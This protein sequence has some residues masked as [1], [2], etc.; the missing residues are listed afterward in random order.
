MSFLH[1]NINIYISNNVEERILLLLAL[2]L[3]HVLRVKEK[4]EKSFNWK[5]RIPNNDVV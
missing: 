4:R 5:S 2:H 1:K 3:T